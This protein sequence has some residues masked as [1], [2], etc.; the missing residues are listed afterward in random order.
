MK[1]LSKKERRQRVI[2]GE[3]TA[4]ASIRTSALARTL[5]VSSETIRRDI[6]ELTEQ[7]LVSRTYG[8]ATGAHLGLQPMFEERSAIEV[9]ERR[10]IV[11]IAAVMVPPGAVLMIDSG[12]TT[13]L[14]AQALSRLADRLTVITNSLGVVSALSMSSGVR[15]IVCPGDYSVRERGVYGPETLSFL[16]KFNVDAAYIGAS[17][18]MMEGPVDVEMAACWVK[19]T[20]MARSEK[21]VLLASASK[22]GR[23]GLELLSPWG[24]VDMLVTDKEPPE[25]LRRKLESENVELRF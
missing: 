24:H 20:M 13:T 12:T 18:L 8:G 7:G 1:R 21:T 3:L 17:G 16:N 10:R 2:V 15:I 23:N 19:R 5:G 4:N 14:F 6:E 22:F 25:A 9:N 11:D